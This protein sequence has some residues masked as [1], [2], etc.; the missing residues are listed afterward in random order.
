MANLKD[1]SVI[2]EKLKELKEWQKKEFMS[3]AARRT[4]VFLH[5]NFRKEGYTNNGFKPWVKRL[6][7]EDGGRRAILVQKAHL[8]NSVIATH[9]A[10]RI[11]VSSNLIY[12]KIHN[13][14]ETN[15]VTPRQRG[16]FWRKHYDAKKEGDTAAAER[17]KRMALS[18]VL[19]MPQRQFMPLPNEGIPFELSE[20]FTADVEKKL[21]LIL[22]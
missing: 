16:W 20:I 10:N 11:F 8:R 5:Q 13:E 22:S 21:N 9:S 18:K 14:G 17:F 6:Q 2:I 4:Q 7:T 3:L 12:A 1:P 19:I 15:V